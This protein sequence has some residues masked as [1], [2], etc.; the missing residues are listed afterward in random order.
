L[1]FHLLQCIDLDRIVH[2]SF[3]AEHIAATARRFVVGRLAVTLGSSSSSPFACL[4]P[5]AFAFVVGIAFVETV[6]RSCSASCWGL[7]SAYRLESLLPLHFT[8]HI[9]H[10][11]TESFVHPPY[12]IK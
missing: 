6:L 7:A 10:L 9:T 3:A 2:S 1:E 5:S 12:F 8:A 4:G 11:L